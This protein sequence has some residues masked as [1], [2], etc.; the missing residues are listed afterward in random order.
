ME[1]LLVS[2]IAT[3]KLAFT[4]EPKPPHNWQGIVKALYSVCVCMYV[5]MYVHVCRYI[6]LAHCQPEW[7]CVQQL[8]CIVS[9]MRVRAVF[10]TSQLSR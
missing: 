9:W 10:T 2:I 5:C 1:S 4:S 6:Q 8:H 7:H 3:N